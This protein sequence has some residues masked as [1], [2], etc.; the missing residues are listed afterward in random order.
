MNLVQ[1]YT[2]A[3]LICKGTEL[4][5]ATIAGM[6]LLGL[7]VVQAAYIVGSGV[8]RFAIAAPDVTVALLCHALV[9]EIYASESVPVANKEQTALAAISA[10]TI[11]QVSR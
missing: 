8:A 2:F 4:D 9:L 3:Q 7:I 10:A 1:T 11:A 5:P 6:H